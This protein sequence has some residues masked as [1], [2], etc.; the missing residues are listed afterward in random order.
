[1]SNP[2]DDSSQAPHRRRPLGK[3]IVLLIVWSVGIV[4]WVLYLALA[5]I[6]LMRI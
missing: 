1:M 2:P 5:A 6:I 4:V 3:W